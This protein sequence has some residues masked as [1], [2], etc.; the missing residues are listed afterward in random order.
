MG[1]LCC[2]AS[3]E[4]AAGA[5]A[6]G[7][8]RE[9][10]AGDRAAAALDRRALLADPARETAR[11]QGELAAA[12]AELRRLSAELAA[13]TVRAPCAGRLGAPPPLLPGA[14]VRR[15][16]ALA[17]LAPQAEQHVDAARSA[18]EHPTPPALRLDRRGRIGATAASWRSVGWVDASSHGLR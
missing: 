7:L 4:L 14:A 6:A 15:G 18:I 8:A 16:D 13:L 3:E 11:L 17:V 1:W 9:A 12:D 10:R 5:D 2:T